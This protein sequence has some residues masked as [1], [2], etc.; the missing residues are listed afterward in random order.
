[1]TALLTGLAAAE[2]QERLAGEQERK[3]WGSIVEAARKALPQDGDRMPLESYLRTVM[4]SARVDSL[5]AKRALSHL[6]ARAE[7]QYTFGQGVS[8]PSATH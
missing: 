4:T 8:R 1:M 3:Q 5:T 7:A 2:V 6:R